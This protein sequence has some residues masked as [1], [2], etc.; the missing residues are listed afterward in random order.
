MKKITNNSDRSVTISG[1][2]MAPGRSI[3]VNSDTLVTIPANV[4]VYLG[5]ENYDPEP[6]PLPTE[7]A[8]PKPKPAPK[9]KA[10]RTPAKK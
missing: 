6:E 7:E 8:T 3:V 4:L 10:K 5:V 1:V 9:R 2:T